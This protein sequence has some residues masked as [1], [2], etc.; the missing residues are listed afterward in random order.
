M[1]SKIKFKN[2]YKF[3]ILELNRIFR[4]WIAITGIELL[5][6]PSKKT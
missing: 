3:V 2:L 1:D 5:L 6:Y 4:Y